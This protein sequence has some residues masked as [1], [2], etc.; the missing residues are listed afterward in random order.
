MT[1]RMRS[2]L[3]IATACAATEAW[4]HPPS[5]IKLSYDA[6]TRML[7]MVLNHD[8]RKPEEHYIESVQIKINGKEAVKQIFFKQA[9]SEKRIASI[10]LEDV[11]PGDQISVTG[12]CNVFGKKTE[13]LKL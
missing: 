1:R 4:A 6:K 7:Q 10:L 8:T 2:F 13:I 11:K 9:D 12:V 5:E 3:I